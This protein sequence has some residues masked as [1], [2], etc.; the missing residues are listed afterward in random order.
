[1]A[2]DACP[3]AP[4]SAVTVLVPTG[5]PVTRPT[6]V[7]GV[8]PGRNADL[9]SRPLALTETASG[10]ERSAGV[11]IFSSTSPPVTRAASVDS[12]LISSRGFAGWLRAAGIEPARAIAPAVPA[13]TSISFMT[14]SR[15]DPRAPALE[16]LLEHIPAGG[17]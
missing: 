16:L 11:A 6:H 13:A 14:F 7:F 12:A 5:R 1:M 17:R 9:T 2:S 3:R 15:R 8:G 4:A 10:A